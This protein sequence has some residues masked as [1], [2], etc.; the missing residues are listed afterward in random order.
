MN[1]NSTCRRLL[2][3][4]GILLIADGIAGIVMPRRRS[5][6]WHVGPQLVKAATEEIADHRR[7]ARAVNAAKTALGVVLLT[8]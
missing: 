3:I 6:L 1:E 8:R 2:Q 7:T 5:L 4:G